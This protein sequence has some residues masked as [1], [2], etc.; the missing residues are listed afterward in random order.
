MIKKIALIGAKGTALNIL[1]QVHDAIMRY[2]YPMEIE[3]IIIDNQIPGDSVG[4]FK[5]IGSTLDIT[6]FINETDL[7]FIF[8][9][10]RMDKM[11][12][13]WDLLQRYKIPPDRMPNFVHPLSYNSADLQLGNG[14]VILS[15]STIQAGVK[16]G[17]N[18]IINSNV[19]IE[20]DTVLGNGNF[21]AA[22]TCIGSHVSI[23]NHCFLGFNSSL[24]ENVILGDKVFVGM[25]SMV[26][27]DFDDCR[28]AG[29][30]ARKI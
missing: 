11:K 17:N 12:E 8:C 16:L 6:K 26:L 15:N 2:A 19:T 24:R 20:H 18:N 27:E 3:G 30:P 4:P 22:N 1:F 14:N 23:A 10:Y 9:L 7:S 13:R 21:I 29:A 5:V 25:H 28:V